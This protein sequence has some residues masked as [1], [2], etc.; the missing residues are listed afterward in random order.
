MLFFMVQNLLKQVT[1]SKFSDTF[2][3]LLFRLRVTHLVFS[4]LDD[5]VDAFTVRYIA[6]VGNGSIA[7]FSFIDGVGNCNWFVREGKETKG[8]G[9]MWKRVGNMNRWK[10]K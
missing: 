7:P 1:R 2:C 8:R 4:V 9:R 5:S 6:G 3:V 10:D